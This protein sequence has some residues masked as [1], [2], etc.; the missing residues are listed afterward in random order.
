MH[1]QFVGMVKSIFLAHFLVDH[2]AQP[3]MS[4]LVF[5]LYQFAAFANYVTAKS[6]FAILLRLIYPR[7]D[8]I[9]I[10]ALFCIAIRRDSVSLLKLTFLSHVQVLSCVMLFI[11]RLKCPWSCFP[12]HF[13][14]LVFCHSVM[15]RV[16]SIVSD[17]R[18]QSSFVFFYVVFES[19]YRCVKAFL[20]AGK[21]SSSL[22][23]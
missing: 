9:G 19:L 3:V 5:L 15:Y 7:F 22:F 1:I 2:L 23:S 12:S 16:V 21:S 14:F 6:A 10:M 20:D 8:M 17:G 11:S 13:C 4:S 18:N